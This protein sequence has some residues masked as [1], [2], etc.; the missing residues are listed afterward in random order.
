[1]NK[2]WIF[3]NKFVIYLAE[4]AVMTWCENRILLFIE[5][6]T[7]AW[8]IYYG[9]MEVTITTQIWLNICGNQS[10]QPKNIHRFIVRRKKKTI[11]S[12]ANKRMIF[13][14]HWACSSFFKGKKEEKNQTK[15]ITLFY[16]ITINLSS[17]CSTNI[18]A[19]NS[20]RMNALESFRCSG[21]WWT[22]QPWIKN[23]I[24]K[25]IFNF[26]IQPK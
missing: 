9:T 18:F 5:I 17:F 7:C 25:R 2:F 26:I 20:L 14:S 3:R 10:N 11:F 13:E 1:M 23:K 24:I 6:P 21:E 19:L 15:S 8:I 12:R 22:H 4:H 16:C